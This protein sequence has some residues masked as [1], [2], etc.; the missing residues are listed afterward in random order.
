MPFYKG[1]VPWTKGKKLSKEHKKKIGISNSISQKGR[2]LSSETKKKISISHIG[3]NTWMKG[4][5]FSEETRRKMSESKKGI[6]PK[7]IFFEGKKNPNWKGGVST[8]NEKQRKLLK[9]KL[10]RDS[11]FSRDNWTCQKCGKR[12]S[13]YLNAHHINPFYLYPELRFLIS[14]GITLCSDCHKVFHKGIEKESE[15]HRSPAL[16]ELENRSTK[17]QNDILKFS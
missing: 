6:T 9:Y 7:N 4:R 5:K 12:G 3:I 10:W 17:L 13:S 14:N 11:V 16:W 1:N 8:E 15:Y 2:I